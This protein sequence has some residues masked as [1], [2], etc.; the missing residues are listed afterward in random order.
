VEHREFLLDR[1]LVNEIVDS[2]GHRP[3]LPDISEALRRFPNEVTVSEPSS[4]RQG[5]ALRRN[6]HNI[7]KIVPLVLDGSVS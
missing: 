7:S 1:E 6:H 5:S 4:R 3:S 2:A